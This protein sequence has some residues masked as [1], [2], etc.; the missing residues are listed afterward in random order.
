MTSLGSYE[1]RYLILGTP[2]FSDG[3]TLYLSIDQGYYDGNRKQVYRLANIDA[4]EE[5]TPEGA[6]AKL[7]L[8][9]RC[10]RA[11]ADN[12]KT[13][14]VQSIVAPVSNSDKEDKY[15][16]YLGVLWDGNKCINDEMV[17]AGHAKYWNGKG[18]H[19]T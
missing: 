13:F 15:R 9:Q 8:V 6:D 4:P 14:H 3:D 10:Q 17:A 11:L 19:P 18:P 16:R 7:W 1:H 5:G 12:P 2:G